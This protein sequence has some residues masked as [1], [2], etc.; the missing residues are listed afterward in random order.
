M[1]GSKKN[2]IYCN[3]PTIEK[4]DVDFYILIYILLICEVVI[5]FHRDKDLDHVFLYLCMNDAQYYADVSNLM[6][7]SL[8]TS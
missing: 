4:I 2:P 3:R 7:V 1:D 8:K 6:V 5:I